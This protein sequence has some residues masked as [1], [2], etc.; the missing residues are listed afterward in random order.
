MGRQSEFKPDAADRIDQAKATY[1][2]TERRKDSQRTYRDS[3]KGQ[4]TLQKYHESDR[5]KLT[6]KKYYESKK[7]EGTRQRRLAKKR[8][9]TQMVT[10]MTNNPGKTIQ[11]FFNA[12]PEL[13]P[14]V[15]E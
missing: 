15:Q 3:E 4:K 7:G 9:E 14:E 10:W 11:D 1:A 8:L 12:H 5:F 13:K 2:Q 6:Q